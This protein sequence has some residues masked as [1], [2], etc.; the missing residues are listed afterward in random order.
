MAWIPYHVLRS[1]TR[2]NLCKNCSSWF[3]LTHLLSFGKMSIGDLQFLSNMKELQKF[4][5]VGS[6]AEFLPLLFIAESCPDLRSFSSNSCAAGGAAKFE[7]FKYVQAHFC[8]FSLT[9]HF[10]RYIQTLCCNPELFKG[11]DMVHLP[12][13]RDLDLRSATRAYCDTKVA[14]NCF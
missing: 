4:S 14:R 7:S 13:L 1:C 3:L 2:S 11:V 9:I 12:A 8:S 6:H 10:Q 5:F